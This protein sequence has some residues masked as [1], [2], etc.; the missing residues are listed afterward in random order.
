MWLGLKIIWHYSGEDCIKFIGGSVKNYLLKS[1]MAKDLVWTEH[2]DPVNHKK[3]QKQKYKFEPFL[4][5]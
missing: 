1:K 2:H 5:L 3:M 4:A